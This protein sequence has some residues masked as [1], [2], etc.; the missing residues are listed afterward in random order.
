MVMFRKRWKH[1]EQPMDLDGFR[2]NETPFSEKPNG[3]FEVGLARPNAWSPALG[4]PTLPT[5]Y[6]A[7][8]M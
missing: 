8:Y 2:G 6:D 4:M 5:L 3:D 1:S 7:D